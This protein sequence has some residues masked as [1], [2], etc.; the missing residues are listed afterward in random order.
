MYLHLSSYLLFPSLSPFLFLPSPPFSPMFPHSLGRRPSQ[1]PASILTVQAVKG[2]C[3]YFTYLFNLNMRV[4]LFN[5]QQ[6]FILIRRMQIHT[7]TCADALTCQT[8]TTPHSLHEEERWGS[9]PL[10]YLHIKGESSPEPCP[11][12]SIA[13][14]D[15]GARLAPWNPSRMRDS[16][17]Q[18]AVTST[19]SLPPSIAPHLHACPSLL[20]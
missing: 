2:H 3:S 4:I 9:L 1:T 8:T 11:D 13:G 5:L 20:L 16:S 12:A 18:H 7:H 19:M 17:F 6:S 10:C 15:K 14:T